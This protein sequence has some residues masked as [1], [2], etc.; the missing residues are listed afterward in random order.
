[1]TDMNGEPGTKFQIGDIV[2]NGIEDGYVVDISWVRELGA[3]MYFVEGT[4]GAGW[5]RAFELRKVWR[6]EQTI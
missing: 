1:M 6:V 2:Y 5:F 3:H 4:M